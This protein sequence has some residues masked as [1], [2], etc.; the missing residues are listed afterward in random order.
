VGRCEKIDTGEN[1]GRHVCIL[2]RSRLLGRT[3]CTALSAEDIFDD[4]VI[5]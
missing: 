3:V 5:K 4:Y 1:M 2:Q